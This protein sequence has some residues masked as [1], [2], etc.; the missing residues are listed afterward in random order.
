MNSSAPIGIFDSGIGGLSVVK[1]IQEILQHETLIYIADSAYAPYGNKPIEQILHRCR[2]LTQYLITQEVKAVIVA[3]NTATAAAVNDLRK[4]TSLPVIAMEPG[5]K[6]AISATRTGTVGVLATENTLL[7]DQ[8][9]N[10]LHRY[11]ADVKVI[12]QPC[13]GLVEQ[14][15][16][17][18][19]D[20]FEIRTMLEDFLAPLLDA[21]ADTIVLGCTHYPL[22]ARQISA[23]TGNK[24]TLINTGPAV[25]QQVKRKLQ[26][27]NLLS[28]NTS[29]GNIDYLTSGNTKQ[30][31]SR[32]STL[33]G[34]DIMVESLPVD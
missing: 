30:V 7:S 4:F 10:L 3:C 14:I 31:S 15:E 27:H 12:S 2:K 22:V 9:T 20:S 6:P 32:I 23:I 5:V 34:E 19:F 28:T 17:G 16:S 18:E 1:E 25:A 33:L 26:E 8:F 24:I 29:P 13:P 11:A 21:G